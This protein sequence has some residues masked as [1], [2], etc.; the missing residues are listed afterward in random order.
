MADIN[1][2]FG[3]Y[4]PDQ[5]SIKLN[6][7]KSLGELLVRMSEAGV[8]L[9]YTLSEFAK[10]PDAPA[11]ETLQNITDERVP[12][13]WQLRTG[14]ATPA[15]LAEEAILLA[16]PNRG[17]SKRKPGDPIYVDVN[18]T[19]KA[20][21]AISKYIDDPFSNVYIHDDFLSE[22]PRK[23]REYDL[24]KLKNVPGSDKWFNDIII[25]DI[26]DPNIHTNV[27]TDPASV[28]ALNKRNNFMREYLND[29]K[30]YR[31]E[32]DTR[33][34]EPIEFDNINKLRD[35]KNQYTHEP[36]IGELLSAA[37]DYDV[38]LPSN[39]KNYRFTVGDYDNYVNTGS[40]KNKKI[41][42]NKEIDN[43]LGLNT[44]NIDNVYSNN[45]ELR[46]YYKYLRNAIERVYDEPEK[47]ND[48][49]KTLNEYSDAIKAINDLP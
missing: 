7:P 15:S 10:N 18:R 39:A 45:P 28:L 6:L 34:N 5:P 20:N 14:N 4:D 37:Y 49:I 16:M 11:T 19:D 33:F 25:S 40:L 3:E 23:Y 27:N 24:D 29:L 26:Q 38:D 17:K 41:L 44:N 21:K 9:A 31:S 2:V 30:E 48:M 13:K 8:P 1:K 35:I 22:S 47:L 32:G 42:R 12:F 36:S 43:E 46:S